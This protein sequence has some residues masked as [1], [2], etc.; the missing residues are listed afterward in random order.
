VSTGADTNNY[1][2]LYRAVQLLVS[3]LLGQPIPIMIFGI[4]WQ[5]SGAFINR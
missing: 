5:H 1:L 4:G 3:A 2:N